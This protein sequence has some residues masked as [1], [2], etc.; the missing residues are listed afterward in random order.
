MVLN[1]R[2][3]MGAWFF[4]PYIEKYLIR[5]VHHVILACRNTTDFKLTGEC[6]SKKY[7][8]MFYKF[9]HTHCLDL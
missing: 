6:V 2:I 8:Q 4:F 3:G 7:L 5:E 1:F 9:C